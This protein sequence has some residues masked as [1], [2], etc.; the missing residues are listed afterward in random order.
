VLPSTRA[1]NPAAD[2]REEDETDERLD[3]RL[4]A[5]ANPPPVPSTWRERTPSERSMNLVGAGLDLFELRD[6]PLIDREA[7]RDTLWRAFTRAVRRER[8]RAV[9][10]RG[11]G[12]VGKTRLA[13]WA[14]EHAEELG[15]ARGLRATHGEGEGPMH[16]L[17]SMIERYLGC[18]D[19]DREQMTYR[20][21]RW[22]REHGVDEPRE[23]HALTELLSPLPA[24]TDE[25]P[26]YARPIHFS[27][28]EER[29]ATIH[30]FLEYASRERPVVVHLDDLQWGR[31]TLAFLDQILR[32]PPEESLQCL[33]VGTVQMESLGHQS[34]TRKRLEDL[35]GR[36]NVKTLDIEPLDADDQRR[37]VANLLAL[38]PST[39]HNVA[40][41]SAGNPLYAI[42]LVDDWIDRD[43]LEVDDDGFVLEDPADVH[44]PED[45]RAVWSDRIETVLGQFSAEETAGIELAAA[46]GNAVD[47]HE[48]AAACR[49]AEVQLPLDLV[50]E[51]VEQAIVKVTEA[52]W[53]FAHGMARETIEDRARRADRWRTHHAACARML[54][55]K[56]EHER[57]RWRYHHRLGNHRFK[58][59]QYEKAI[60]PLL[61]A[62]QRAGRL[63][64]TD[65][66]H[67][68]LDRIEKA[69]DRSEID[70][71][72]PR[73]ADLHLQRGR[74]LMAARGDEQ[75]ATSHFE[76][77]HDI[78]SRSDRD[79]LTA[80]ALLC[81]SRLD[82]QKSNY[83]RA[84]DQCRRATERLDARAHPVH[85][86]RIERSAG[87][88][89]FQLGRL[90][91]ALE[92]F[93]GAKSR[94]EG[95]APLERAKVDTD[96]ARVHR[97]NGDLDA[98]EAR[99]ESAL[100]IFDEH[101]S[102]YGRAMTLN[103]L[104]NIALE[105]EDYARAEELLSSARR[106]ARFS[107]R[108]DLVHIEAGPA[109]LYVRRGNYDAAAHRAR[110][111][112]EEREELLAPYLR[113][114]V[115]AVLIHALCGL[116][117]YREAAALTARLHSTLDEYG[118]TSVD[119]AQHLSEAT[120]QLE[121]A[122]DDEV[123]STITEAAAECWNRLG[124]P[125][126]AEEIRGAGSN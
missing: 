37:L 47:R 39:A 124:Q 32:E 95:E 19:L 114:T 34:R 122:T 62:S 11:A 63:G 112:L 86:G 99:L 103:G 36:P 27:S 70:E 2:H 96:I 82:H 20:I 74:L 35:A 33:V 118:F 92:V 68:L 101:G 21:E 84:L 65:E 109:D 12:G 107:H 94:L 61:R 66:V 102:N 98:A 44:T 69:F 90:E 52:G 106:A 64:E 26:S 24:D 83:D 3:P 120:R 23:W 100:D 15:A 25:L 104:A 7:E 79:V 28:V 121:T 73:R 18:V 13:R 55:N 108:A 43:V 71:D 91:E 76:H 31:S 45:T 87:E 75:A 50:D 53:E 1:R 29:Y 111:L 38:H 67:Y 4:P 81:R 78:A 125:T 77:A 88:S 8:P 48:W 89:L 59:Q 14:R 57:D 16:G 119:V 40:Q 41:R 110:N 85:A 5:P 46:L 10:L 105:R 17:R 123:T 93:A 30:R 22:M 126:R 113:A 42:K 60:D 56:D 51:L 115:K 117:E 6:F 116:D 54:E 58:A 9:L 72:D 97:G 80:R 49:A